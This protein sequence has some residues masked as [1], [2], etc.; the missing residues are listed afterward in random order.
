MAA[1]PVTF[2][3][4]Q[5]YYGGYMPQQY[6]P[7]P[8]YPY[9]TPHY[10]YSSPIGYG[11]NYQLYYCNGYYSYTPCPYYPKHHAMNYGNYGNYYYMP[12]SM[13]EYYRPYGY[14]T[15]WYNW[16]SSFNYNYNYNSNYNYNGWG[17]GYLW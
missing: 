6:Y 13:D 12:Y 1:I 14:A 17:G 4:A 2:T 7:Q 15:N 5:G 9:P 16:Q 11:Q 3:F 8:Q 10:A